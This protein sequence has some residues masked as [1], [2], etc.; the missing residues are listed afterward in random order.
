M[1]ATMTVFLSSTNRETVK[2]ALG[3]VKV[4]VTACPPPL[5]LPHLDKLVPALLKWTHGKGN[6]LRNQTRHTLAA[7]IKR[8]S[9]D[10]VDRAAGG[11]D[12]DGKV[13]SNIRREIEQSK[14]KKAVAKADRKDED[15][16]DVVRSNASNDR[17]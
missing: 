10:K 3:Y 11:S 13:L 5:I 7:M 9:F 6:K 16:S 15:E 14:K 17:T 2:A 1:I 4:A 12:D 8:Y